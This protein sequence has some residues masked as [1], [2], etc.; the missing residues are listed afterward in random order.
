MTIYYSIIIILILL[1]LLGNN[2]RNEKGIMLTMFFVM[3]LFQG[4]RW[5]TGADWAQY[6]KT[7][8]IL[9]WDNLFS[10][11]RGGNRSLEFLYAF[12]N[13]LIKTLL[14]HYTFFLLISC[15]F[16]NATLL[17][18]TNKYIKHDKAFVYLLMLSHSALFPV[19]NAFAGIIIV[20]GV[21]FIINRDLIK[22][23]F[24]VIISTLIH[25][26][27][28]I[29]AIFYFF[30]RHINKYIWIGFYIL[31]LVISKYFNSILISFFS[32]PIFAG[33]SLSQ[34]GTSYLENYATWIDAVDQFSYFSFILNGLLLY[35][36][37]IFRDK[38]TLYDKKLI[39]FLVN[40]AGFMLVLTQIS[41]S[42][43]TVNELNRITYFCSFA[44]GTLVVLSLVYLAKLIRIAKPLVLIVLSLLSY[45]KFMSNL[46]GTYKDL[47]VP[48]YSV[49]ENSPQRDKTI[50]N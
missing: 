45:K 27:G 37:L 50:I 4:L 43:M 17:H 30:N 5:H 28:I 1:A 46:E 48:Y 19:R 20:W 31:S 25:T 10:F 2:K 23:V 49:F 7:F 6:E 15:G 22:Y 12:T 33:T 8:E 11:D 26:F 14:G 35:A 3:T 44:F 16:I 40:M 18:F 9:N 47:M 21:Q 36:F 41:R 29:T 13:V 34:V 32:L 39:D 38:Q 42:G 24:L